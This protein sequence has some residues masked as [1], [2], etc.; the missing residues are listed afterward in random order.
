MK[1]TLSSLLPSLLLVVVTALTAS[2]TAAAADDGFVSLMDGKTFNGWKKAVEN[3]DTWTVEDGAFVARGPRCHLF[4]VGDEEPF[5]NFHLKMEVMTKPGS[6]GGIYFHTRYQEEGWPRWGFE[7]QVN[8]TH[9]DWIKTGS[10]YGLVNIARAAAP[11]NQ[12]W[13]HEIIVQGR[14]VTVI[15]NGERLF[16]YNEPVGAGAGRD[17]TRKLDRGTFALQAHDPE[18]VIYY[19]NIQVKRLN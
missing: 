13:T 1:R 6:N 18:S 15:I 2:L 4:Y 11:D 3:P 5:V 9:S 14:S 19:R 16:Q 7:S 12:W 8:A 17:F 10:L